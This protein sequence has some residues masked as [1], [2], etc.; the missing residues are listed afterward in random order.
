MENGAGEI[1]LPDFRFTIKLQ[2]SKE[3]GT[4]TYK[5]TYMHT[6]NVNIDQRNIIESPEIN[7]GT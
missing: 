5:H 6:H 4:G 2:S 7:S 1:R 3:N